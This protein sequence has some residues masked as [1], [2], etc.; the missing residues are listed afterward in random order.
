[1]ID[2]RYELL[3][4]IITDLRAGRGV[5]YAVEA[6]DR[7]VLSDLK[8]EDGSVRIPLTQGQFAVIDAADWPLVKD[9]SWFAVRDASRK[10]Y[11][12]RSYYARTKINGKAVSMHRLLMGLPSLRVDHR[13]CD[14]LNNRRLNLRLVTSSQSTQNRRGVEAAQGRQRFQGCL[15]SA[16][17]SRR[18]HWMAGTH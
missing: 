2:L 12:Q 6:Y 10:D 17:P 13:D 15:R 18:D 16:K 8:L 14:G 11:E 5:P 1:M 4:Q 9:Y 7:L 3:N